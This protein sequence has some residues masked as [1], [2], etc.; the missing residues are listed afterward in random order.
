MRTGKLNDLFI[1][2]RNLVKKAEALHTSLIRNEIDPLAV[3]SRIIKLKMRLEKI[4]GNDMVA[5]KGKD[6][7]YHYVRDRELFSLLQKVLVYKQQLSPNDVEIIMGYGSS[8][9]RH[10]QQY[11]SLLSEMH[12]YCGIVRDYLIKTHEEMRKRE[13]TFIK[14]DATEKGIMMVHDID[15][16]KELR[17][18]LKDIDQNSS[19]ETVILVFARAIEIVVTGSIYIDANYFYAEILDEFQKINFMPKENAA[20]LMA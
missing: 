12:I 9:A 19:D 1:N 5:L 2:Q 8:A 10:F 4:L 15:T 16:V 20:L 18:L 11:L 13:L 7:D 17:G 6:H 3:P 14:I